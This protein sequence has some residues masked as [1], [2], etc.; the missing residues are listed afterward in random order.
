MSTPAAASAP[1]TARSKKGSRA[2]SSTARS[3]GDESEGFADARWQ[4]HQSQQSQRVEALKKIQQSEVDALSAAV[5]ELAAEAPATAPLLSEAEAE[6][7]A[8]L[9]RQEAEDDAPSE[10]PDALELRQ[11][12]ALCL[13]S[14]VKGNKVSREVAIK[15]SAVAALATLLDEKADTPTEGSYLAAMALQ[16]LGLPDAGAQ[17]KALKAAPEHKRFAK[18]MP[19]RVQTVKAVWKLEREPEHWGGGGGDAA[20][21]GEGVDQERAERRGARSTRTRS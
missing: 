19:A 20:A 12:A 2:I 16:A 9:R 6:E 7:E 8:E 15:A 3:V 11:N 21:T 17:E 18:N 5:A 13:A 1:T 4:K 10:T 14:L